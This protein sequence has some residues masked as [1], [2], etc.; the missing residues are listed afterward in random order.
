MKEK[1]CKHTAWLVLGIAVILCAAVLAACIIWTTFAEF[2]AR[3]I[4]RAVRY[5]LAA[6]TSVL[7]FSLGEVLV[8]A[9][10]A[11]VVVWLITAAIS[12]IGKL[13]K[14]RQTKL[15]R[16]ILLAPIALAGIIFCLFVLTLF[17]SYHRVS[18]EQQLGYTSEVSD[19]EVFSAF[20]QAADALNTLSAA[21]E[22]NSEGETEFD[23]DFRAMAEAVRKAVDKYAAAHKFIQPH[24]FRAKGIMLSEPMTYTRISGV[25]T[26]FTGESNVNTNYA[27]FMLVYT[28]AHEYF[29]ARG[30]APENECNFLAFAALYESD[31]EYLR[32]SALANMFL[33]LAN[34]AYG[35]DPDRYAEICSTLNENF[36]TEYRTYCDFYDRYENK[37]VSEMSDAVNDAYLKSQ[38]QQ[39]GV[40]SYGMIA[41]FAANYFK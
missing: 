26:F 32:Y 14:R 18:L 1:R 9:A 30:I 39:S 2:F 22:L 7:P 37:T 12:I 8:L 41:A 35:I 23:G 40:A 10:A 5:A 38:G 34:T 15:K 36:I 29:H 6:I 28:M 11:G 31:N 25:Y 24:G 27:D 21:T 20:S 4:A 19:D 17:P 16:R 3:Y 13:R 33:K